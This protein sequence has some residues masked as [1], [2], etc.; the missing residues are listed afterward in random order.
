MNITMNEA[1]RPVQ[2]SWRKRVSSLKNV[3]PIFRMLWDAAPAV[4]AS[5][6]FFRLMAALLP[7]TLLG[8]TRRIIDNIYGVASHQEPLTN[9]FWFLVALEFGLAGLGVVLVRLIDFCDTVITERY[10][11]HVNTRIMRHAATLDLVSFEDPQFHDKLERA[12]VQGADRIGMIQASGQLI[13]EF[14]STTTL[15]AGIYLISPWIL[16]ALVI[17][18]VPAF[19]GETHFAFLGYSLNVQQTPARREL[20]YLRILGASKES[21]KEQKLFGLGQFFVTRYSIISDELRDQTVILARRKLFVGS[22]LGLLGTVG[23]YGTYAY[24]IYLTVHGRL[25]LGTLTFLAGAIAGA[26]SNIQSIFSTFSNIADHA[27]FLTDLIEFFSVRPKICSK[28]NCVPGPRPILQGFEFKN[29]SFG[30]PGRSN[31]VLENVNFRLEPGERIALVGG[32]GQGKTTIVKLLTRLYDVTSGQILLD[33]VDLR[34]YNVDDLWKEI[35]VIFQDFMRYEMTASENIAIGRIEERENPFRIR[36][37]ALKSM[38]E[39]V[40]HKLPKRY[41]Q[42]LGCRFA[43]GV[44][45]SGGEWQ[46]MALARAY[47]RDAQLLILDEPTAALDAR[48]E[49]EVFRTVRRTDR[50][51][52][53]RFDFASFFHGS[54]GRSHSRSEKR[55]DCRARSALLNLSK[56]ADATPKCLNCR[57]RTTDEFHL[58]NRRAVFSVFDLETGQAPVTKSGALAVDP[59]YQKSRAPFYFIGPID[60]SVL[61]NPP[62]SSAQVRT[63]SINVDLQAPAHPFPHYWERMFGSGRANLSLRESYRRDLR[64]VKQATGFEYVR[65]HAIFH[66]E[67]GVYDE[68][69]GGKPVYNFSYVDQIY[70]GLLENHVRPFVELSFMPGK[71][72]AQQIFH[73]FWYRPIVSPPKDWNK[74]EDLISH[75]AQHLG[76]SLRY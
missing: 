21:A 28:P 64:E 31:L 11:S 2:Q 15:A 46:K 45:L 35:A 50:G 69:A 43:G 22:L 61:L 67:N 63:E 66:D 7:V 36:A 71:L 60:R 62:T 47:L 58:M 27:L 32:N 74:W 54:D 23:Y 17:C 55:N 1:E 25:T 49:H 14:I 51:E 52:N 19:L 56:A 20:D 72:A 37:A 29:V 12:R 57:R 24:G 40:V 38:A 33:G 65:F 39:E 73:P 16:L 34:E 70:D 8:I 18:V 44:D 41:D 30:Y 26:S 76:G 3:P 9:E 75:F 13:Q 4:V 10:T 48:S 68:D 59:P 5:G 6:V 42:M 53:V